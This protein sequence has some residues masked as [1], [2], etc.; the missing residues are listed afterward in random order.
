M[1]LPASIRTVAAEAV[2][3][4]A[5]NAA[6]APLLYDAAAAGIRQTIFKA[7][8]H[9]PLLN[10]T[11]TGPFSASAHTSFVAAVLLAHSYEDAASNIVASAAGR[12]RLVAPPPG[13]TA[14]LAASALSLTPAAAAA[15]EYAAQHC[16]AGSFDEPATALRCLSRT[17]RSVGDFA[18]RSGR[19]FVPQ[20][21]WA[22]H[23]ARIQGLQ[24][25][26]DALTALLAACRR[27]A[28]LVT[29]RSAVPPETFAIEARVLA[30]AIGNV[31]EQLRPF[32]AVQLAQQ[33]A[34][35]ASV[36]GTGG[37]GS[38][39]AAAGRAGALRRSSSSA[40]QASGSGTGGGGSTALVPAAAAPAAVDGSGVQGGDTDGAVIPIP[41]PSDAE[42]SNGA[43]IPSDAEPSSASPLS[44]ASAATHGEPPLSPQQP[45]DLAART[46]GITGRADG[47]LSGGFGGVLT[48]SQLASRTVGISNYAS[49]GASASSGS[50]SG[51]SSSGG[52]AAVSGAGS[53][54]GTSIGSSALPVAGGRQHA[55]APVASV[56]TVSDSSGGGA[57]AGLGSLFGG[58]SKKPPS[59]AAQES[60]PGAAAAGG[61]ST[62]ALG[63]AFAGFQK[64]VTALAASVAVVPDAGN[65]ANLNLGSGAAAAPGRT[66][67]ALPDSSA[68]AA[69]GAGAAASVSG[70]ASATTA[71]VSPA[72]TIA[73]SLGALGGSIGS[74][75][76]ATR[77]FGSAAS[78]V[79]A[80]SAEELVAHAAL[81]ARVADTAVDI[82]RWLDAAAMGAALEW[83]SAAV[84]TTDA[85]AA[86]APAGSGEATAAPPAAVSAASLV[87]SEVGREVLSFC[88]TS[89]AQMRL[90][91][92]RAA[93][94]RF[95]AFVAGTL[96]PLL[97]AD[98]ETLAARAAAASAAAGGWA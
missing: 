52:A 18:L 37:G 51:S 11:P 72:S 81:V 96:L 78:A 40:G 98:L 16:V 84:A 42:P 63:R 5:A 88:R 3:A 12:R 2:A 59:A 39:G 65:S 70:D 23:G 93:A 28:T 71:Q 9:N 77:L 13:T 25:K 46:V 95:A 60:I 55:A 10:C 20:G 45:V 35:S 64:Q 43:V 22:Q 76:A 21:V 94:L 50:G 74:A 14:P 19:A 30:H 49:A 75:L 66:A 38:G 90:P 54:S 62:S 82:W 80:L 34:S 97:L 57:R 91:G 1:D 48:S 15:V 41:M 6:S 26:R 58:R 29:P 17:V 86:T 7:V 24:L 79:T 92:V 89:A 53:A 85:M 8:G 61:S 31:A 69:A 73:A 87:S 47:G 33:L 83:A 36:A 4:H 44:S 68:A 32:I 27:F 56:G 67:A